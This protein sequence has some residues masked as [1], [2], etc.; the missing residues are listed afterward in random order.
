MSILASTSTFAVDCTLIIFGLKYFKRF[1]IFLLVEATLFNQKMVLHII[2]A[3]EKFLF[4]VHL[5]KSFNWDMPQVSKT[6]H[7]NLK[8]SIVLV[9]R[10]AE[11]KRGGVGNVGVVCFWWN[12]RFFIRCEGVWGSLSLCINRSGSRSRKPDMDQSKAV[13]G[14]VLGVDRSWAPSLGVDRSWAH[15]F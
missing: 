2:A 10:V 15:L 1:L 3:T 6:K 5:S 11:S 4:K 8:R 9:C 14:Y 13:A 12:Q 7:T